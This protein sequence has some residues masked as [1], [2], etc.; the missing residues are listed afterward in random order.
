MH[1][2]FKNKIWEGNVFRK[3]FLL[4]LLFLKLEPWRVQGQVLETGVASISLRGGQRHRWQEETIWLGAGVW[5]MHAHNCG[6]ED[7]VSG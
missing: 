1:Y 2:F 4:L 6:W 3:L 5:A 7:Q